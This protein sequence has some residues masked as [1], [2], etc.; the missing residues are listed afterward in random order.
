VEVVP[1]TIWCVAG[2]RARRPL[3]VTLSRPLCVAGSGLADH[4]SL[5]VAFV[6]AGGALEARDLGQAG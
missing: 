2:G 1:L 4:H 5:A 3:V 6:R